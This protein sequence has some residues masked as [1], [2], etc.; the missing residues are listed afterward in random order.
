MVRKLELDAMVWSIEVNKGSPHATFLGAGASLTSGVPSAWTCVLQWKRNI[1]ETK[2]PEL[3]SAV[4]EIRD[5]R[6]QFAVR[7]ITN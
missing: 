4:A 5:R 7:S 2:N 1:F 6:N 3:K